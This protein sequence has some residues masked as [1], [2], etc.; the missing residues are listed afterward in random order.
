ME[1]IIVQ[2]TTN[3]PK[4]EAGKILL[5]LVKTLHQDINEK[6]F[7]VY[8]QKYLEKYQTFLNEKTELSDGTTV[9]THEGVRSACL[10]LVKHF[11]YLFTFERHKDI[12]K[13]TNSLEGHF[14]HI[15]DVV[16]VHRGVRRKH[17]EKILTSILLAS[18]IAPSDK[19]LDEILLKKPAKMYL[20]PDFSKKYN[21]E[22]STLT[23]WNK[24]ID[25][26]E[27]VSETRRWANKLTI[28]ILFAL[29][30]KNLETGNLRGI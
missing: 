5:A 29:Y 20:M 1:R 28:N 7:K 21:V 19:K 11:P 25:K 16:G 17:M 27:T 23:N 18:T 10:S 3:K 26:K 4:L 8:L 24:L 30:R 9:W 22:N 12:P 14:S 15:R 6:R 13:T 2:G